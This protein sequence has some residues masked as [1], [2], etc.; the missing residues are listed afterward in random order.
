MAS[1]VVYSDDRANANANASA[2][3]EENSSGS[4]GARSQ[5]ASE[6][7]L[8]ELTQSVSASIYEGRYENGRRYHTYREGA[9]PLPE[10]EREQDRLDLIQHW[11]GLVL[12]GELVRAPLN[13]D[14][15]DGAGDDP[16]LQR[17]VLDIGTGTGLWALDF[18]DA[19]PDAQVIGTDLSVIQPEWTAPNCHFIIDDAESDWVFTDKESF[20]YVH[21]RYL[22]PGIG[23]WG[24]L[25]EQSFEHL[26]PG[27]WAE[28]QEISAWF[29]SDEPGFENSNIHYWQVTMD[30]ATSRIG[31]RFNRA[32][33]QKQHMI[34]AGFANV[35]QEIIEIPVGT[36]DKQQLEVGK[37]ALLNVF[38]GLAPTSLAI[39]SRVL[40]WDMPQIETLLAAVRNEFLYSKWKTHLKFYFTYGQKP[41]HD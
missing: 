27:G 28:S 4:G 12:K 7:Y 1:G 26:R 8:D 21:V 2:N 33:E 32:H 24:R 37:C 23:D 13:F 40:D 39:F 25:W 5:T 18:A 34:N 6:A 30:D 17:R 9:Y 11:F 41:T 15:G 31:K 29:Y 19:H 22:Y 3:D 20:D 35:T 14:D 10:D 36:W 16:Q 38:E